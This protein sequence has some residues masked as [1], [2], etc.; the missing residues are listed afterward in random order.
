MAIP[1][2]NP[3]IHHLR[4]LSCSLSSEVIISL[5]LSSVSD[6]PILFGNFVFVFRDDCKLNCYLDH[7]ESGRFESRFVT[8]KVLESNSV[9]LKDMAGSQLGVW[10]AHGEGSLGKNQKWF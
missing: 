7:N 3:I 8:V 5:S 2:C 4:V 1:I 6:C 10:I 9:M